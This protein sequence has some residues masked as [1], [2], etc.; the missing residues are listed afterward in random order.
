M[1]AS[2]MSFWIWLA[3]VVFLFYGEPDVWEKLHD[4]AMNVE[5]CK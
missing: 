5:V 3:V 4:Y 2:D 1:S